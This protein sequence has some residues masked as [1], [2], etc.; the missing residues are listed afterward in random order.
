MDLD[1]ITELTFGR[2]KF[3]ALGAEARG[4]RLSIWYDYFSCPQ[5]QTSTAAE[6]TPKGGGRGDLG[7]AIDSIPAYVA[8]CSFFCVL[9][10]I[11]ESP[12]KSRVFSPNL[13]CIANQNNIE[14]PVSRA[15]ERRPCFATSSHASELH[16]LALSLPHSHSHT[17]LYIL[18][19]VYVR[20]S[21]I[22]FQD[23]EGPEGFK[24]EL[25]DQMSTRYCFP[26]M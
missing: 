22:R 19:T 1:I 20:H 11:V 13:G 18:H 23:F 5:L 25:V 14:Q 10:P 2:S 8:K 12:D 4:Q 9:C 21:R 24:T 26:C 15:S 17:Y 7:K 3:L 16:S 6:M